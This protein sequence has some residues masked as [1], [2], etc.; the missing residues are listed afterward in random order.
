MMN[1]DA[2]KLNQLSR[3]NSSETFGL[4]A[5][6]LQQNDENEYYLIE[7]HISRIFS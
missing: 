2:T 5:E 1:K 6:G 3:S 7:N 4:D